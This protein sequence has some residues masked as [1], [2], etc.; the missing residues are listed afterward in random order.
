M[1]NDIDIYEKYEPV[2]FSEDP[3]KLIYVAHDNMTIKV[4][5]KL[6]VDVGTCWNENQLS[7]ID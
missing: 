6:V 3:C 2:K 4:I 7:S 5:L 1:T